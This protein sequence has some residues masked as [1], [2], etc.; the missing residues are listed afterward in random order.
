MGV[1]VVVVVVMMYLQLSCASATLIDELLN[2]N[3]AEVLREYFAAC[4]G[5]FRPRIEDSS[6]PGWPVERLE[7]CAVALVKAIA[8]EYPAQSN[9]KES[10]MWAKTV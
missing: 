2:E 6:R 3:N 5:D 7:S 9:A 1:V 4:E 8:E 10:K